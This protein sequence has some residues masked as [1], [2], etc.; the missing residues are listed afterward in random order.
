MDQAGPSGGCGEAVTSLEGRAG[1]EAWAQETKARQHA[2]IVAASSWELALQTNL[3]E[4][5]E[6]TAARPSW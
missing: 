5:S 6:Q 2:R 3:R 4:G 1:V